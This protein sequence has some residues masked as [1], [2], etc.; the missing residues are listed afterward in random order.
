MD[1]IEVNGAALRGRGARTVVL[2]H[3]MGGALESC[4]SM[5]STSATEWYWWEWR[6]AEF[7]PVRLPETLAARAVEIGE[8]IARSRRGNSTGPSGTV[9]DVKPQRALQP[10]AQLPRQQP[11]QTNEPQ[12]PSW[13]GNKTATSGEAGGDDPGRLVGQHQEGQGSD[14]DLGLIGVDRP[15]VDDRYADALRSQQFAQGRTIGRQARLGGTVGGGVGEGIESRQAGYEGNL[16]LLALAHAGQHG[17]D[18][19]DGAVEIDLDEGERAGQRLERTVGPITPEVPRIGDGKVDRAPRFHRRH[20]G[21]H[22]LLIGNLAGLL[23][24]L[25][26]AHFAEPGRVTQQI[27]VAR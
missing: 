22:G 13:E 17:I 9:A 24:Y 25:G 26:A 21:A 2:L 11:T 23:Q 19:D 1:F 5:R 20:E 18:R 4:R 3:K 7:M 8:V 16:S 27:L 6:S 10:G 14:L 15:G 12:Q